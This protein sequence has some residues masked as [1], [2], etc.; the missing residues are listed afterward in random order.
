MAVNC[1]VGSKN[2][3]AN[4][5]AECNLVKDESLF[6]TVNNA[7]NVFTGVL[8]VVA[9]VVIIYGGVQYVLATGDSSKLK[10]AKDTIM[11]G[12]IG[13]VIAILAFAIVNFVVGVIGQG[14]T[15]ADG[16]DEGEETGLVLNL[17]A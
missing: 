12:I 13:L 17:G 7:I 3:T 2:E 9:A 5:Y 4:T 14:A 16:G 10:R 15:P 6:P 1:P 11:Y 8:G